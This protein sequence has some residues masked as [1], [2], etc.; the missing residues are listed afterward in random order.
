MTD[1]YRNSAG[2]DAS[3]LYDPDVVGDGLNAT[4]LRRSDGT[5][6]RYAAAKYGSPGPALGQRDS[7]GNDVGPQW[8]A[9][10][11]A[12]YALSINGQTFS[13]AAA[14]GTGACGASIQFNAATSGWS[15]TGSSTSGGHVSTASG[16][17]PVGAVSVQYS[18]SLTT[19][20]GAGSIG[21]NASTKT[22]LT[23]SAVDFIVS[24][25]SGS[26]QSGDNI[27]DTTVTI[28]FYNSA[29]S[30]V[31]TTTIYLNVDAQGTA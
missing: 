8:A 17:L 11:T 25:N 9:K 22:N 13:A 12:Q 6:L 1:G 4:W 3:Q 23:S 30:A 28:V 7:S 31:S 2:V 24:A 21:N 15:I 18:Y 20:S 10:G 14:S 19:S 5:T 29:G 16:S 27:R 26:P